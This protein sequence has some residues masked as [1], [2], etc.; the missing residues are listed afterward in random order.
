MVAI[1]RPMVSSAQRPV[2]LVA[3]HDV[4][5]VEALGVEHRRRVGVERHA[6]GPARPLR[7]ARVAVADGGERRA[8]GAS[9]AQAL[10]W[11]GA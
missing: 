8:L 10:R 2:G 7:R 5:E 11:F 6:E 3:G 9:A 4:D 1:P